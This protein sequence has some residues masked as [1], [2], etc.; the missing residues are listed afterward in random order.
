MIWFAQMTELTIDGAQFFLSHHPKVASVYE[1]QDQRTKL[2]SV[3][4]KDL[5]LVE[6]DNLLP[7]RFSIKPKRTGDL[8]VGE[9][10]TR[11][12]N[13]A[14]N[15]IMLN[16]SFADFVA[17]GF[18]IAGARGGHNEAHVPPSARWWMMHD[19]HG[20]GIAGGKGHFFAANLQARVFVG[21]FACAPAVLT[22]RPVVKGGIGENVIGF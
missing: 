22:F 14:I 17:C 16:K 2:A 7:S 9:E 21:D 8:S 11:D 12:D 19:P 5:V 6:G 1:I 18:R 13:N 10:L 3:Y 20:I 4:E 15:I